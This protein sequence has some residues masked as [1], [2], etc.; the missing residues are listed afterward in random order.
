MH[1]VMQ[2]LQPRD[3]VNYNVICSGYG[4]AGLL[5]AALYVLQGY[6][7]PVKGYW[8]MVRLALLA[9][10]AL[11]AHATL[12]RAHALNATTSQFSPFVPLLLVF[13]VIRSR[14]LAVRHAAA[15]KEKSS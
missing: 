7:E 3:D 12:P 5:C 15:A 11:C 9:R 13:L 4:I 6:A 1:A 2:L 14:W 10:H 8:I